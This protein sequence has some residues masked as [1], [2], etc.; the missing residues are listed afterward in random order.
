MKK[1]IVYLNGQLIP[2]SQANISVSDWGFLYGFGL[3]ETMR[4]VNGHIFLLE[5]HLERL[6]AAAKELSI[7]SGLDAGVLEKAC[8]D[9]LAASG[10]KDARVRLT[11]SATEDAES[12]TVLVT[13]AEYTPSDKYQSGFRAR[14]VAT[15]RPATPL[16]GYKTTSY[17]A[18]ILA[19]S[20]AQ[21]DGYDEAIFVNDRGFISEGSVSN[22]FA[23][24]AGGRLLT[25]SLSSGLLP[26][27]TRR[28]VL[29][30]AA[31]LG[32]PVAEAEISPAE[33]LQAS[34]SFFTNSLM[35]IMPLAVVADAS[36]KAKDI[37]MGKLGEQT[38]RLIVAYRERFQKETA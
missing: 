3:F 30:L 6:L 18:N 15:P 9:V 21:A 7:A 4:A 14:L 29:E 27:I 10:L 28:L 2:S 35:G 16:L 22:I 36:G 34:E 11:V 23:V 5:W 31:E 1:D 33:L 8:Q 13:A 24:T 20:Q 37:G 38:L 12:P 19:R 25:P 17:M 26:G 32:M